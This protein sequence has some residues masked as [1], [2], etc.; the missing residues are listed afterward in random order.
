MARLK[1]KFK[2]ETQGFLCP[3]EKSEM[4]RNEAN[5]SEK[6]AEPIKDI[7]NNKYPYTK[8][9]KSKCRAVGYTIP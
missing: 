7:Y 1:K 4:K 5:E 3:N 9:V 8:L 6:S 2:K